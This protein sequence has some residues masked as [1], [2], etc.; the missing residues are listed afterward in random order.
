MHQGHSQNWLSVPGTGGLMVWHLS[1][2]SKSNGMRVWS[3]FRENIES[4]SGIKLC[5]PPADLRDLS[6]LE[7]RQGHWS[8]LMAQED[9][10]SKGQEVGSRGKSWDNHPGV[11]PPCQD[12]VGMKTSV[13]A[14]LPRSH[15]VLQRKSP[16]STWDQGVTMPNMDRGRHSCHLAPPAFLPPLPPAHLDSARSELLSASRVVEWKHT[17]S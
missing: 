2:A 16:L 7:A 10:I 8:Y 3:S 5:L 15:K 12:K 4:Y 6:L 14:A 13:A 9:L 11:P 17:E 1:R